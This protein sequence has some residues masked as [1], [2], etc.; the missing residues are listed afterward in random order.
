MNEKREKPIA[1]CS[2]CGNFVYGRSQITGRCAKKYGGKRCR[3]VNDAAI[4][5][6]FKECSTCGATGWEGAN[7]CSG[8]DGKGWFPTKGGAH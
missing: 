5:F 1:V 4:E 2:A 3:G 7:R 6:D 8:C